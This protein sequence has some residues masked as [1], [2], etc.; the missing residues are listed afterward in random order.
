MGPFLWISRWSFSRWISRWGQFGGLPAIN[1]L[2]YRRQN[3]EGDPTGC[4]NS[5]TPTQIAPP[6]VLSWESKAENGIKWISIFYTINPS[7]SCATEIKAVLPLP[8]WGAGD[9]IAR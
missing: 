8:S 1:Q 4:S 7:P 3:D 6:K 2:H 5:L 9:T